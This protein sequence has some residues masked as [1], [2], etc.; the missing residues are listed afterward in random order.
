MLD[1][2]GGRAVSPAEVVREVAAVRDRIEGVTLQGG[3]PFEQAAPLAEVARAVR[4]LGLSVMAFSGY[5]LEELRA[6]RDPGVAALLGETDLLVDGRFDRER[7]E[8]ERRWV[9]SSNQRFHFLTDRY[10]P[11]IERIRP[12]EPETTVELRIA[13]DGRVR[14]N[15]WPE[16]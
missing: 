9:G 8:R 7:P 16:L 13:G 11:G 6:A 14:A 10:R 4:A 2:A 5:T 1:P 15:G 3:E 12:G